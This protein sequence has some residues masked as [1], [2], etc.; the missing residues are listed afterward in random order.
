MRANTT[1]RRANAKPIPASAH[2]LE[3]AEREQLARKLGA[4][5]LCDVRTARKFLLGEPIRTQHVLLRLRAAF[6][7]HQRSETPM[8]PE[9]LVPLDE[10]RAAAS[11]G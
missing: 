6:T 3:P 5:C 10:L 9:G 8:A 7:R 4:E 2:V 11:T 1:R